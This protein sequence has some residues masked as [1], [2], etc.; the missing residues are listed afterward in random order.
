MAHLPAV[1]RIP[2]A[3]CK[4]HFCL[5]QSFLTNEPPHHPPPW[6]FI[7]HNKFSFIILRLPVYPQFYCQLHTVRLTQQE[8]EITREEAD[9]IVWRFKWE[10][11]GEAT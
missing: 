3:A 1:P 4:F 7:K 11:L 8:G 10:W 6:T 9:G 2:V 5:Q